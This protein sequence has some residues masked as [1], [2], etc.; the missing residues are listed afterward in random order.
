MK[1]LRLWELRWL[2]IGCKCKPRCPSSSK[3]PR[4]DPQCCLKHRISQPRKGMTVWVS[5]HQGKCQKPEDTF[6]SEILRVREI[7]WKYILLLFSHWV[8]SNSLQPHELYVACQ[9]SLSLRFPRQEYWSGLLFSPPE[10][11]PDPGTKSRLLQ[12]DSLP[13]TTW[14]APR[15]DLG[16]VIMNKI[17][18]SF[19][20]LISSLSIS[21]SRCSRA[22]SL[23][24]FW[25]MF[26]SCLGLQQWL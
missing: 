21:G 11:L 24:L 16:E 22:P 14:E 12:V 8:M 13:M 23:A 7:R 26:Y 25:S 19:R 15:I 5:F 9:A 10:D 1:K 18:I 2:A 6:A 4:H 3:D 17:T 20:L